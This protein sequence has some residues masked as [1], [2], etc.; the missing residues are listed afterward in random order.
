MKICFN[1]SHPYKHSVTFSSA[2]KSS[3]IEYF[4][5]KLVREI[6]HQLVDGEINY[7]RSKIEHKDK[8]KDSLKVLMNLLK[9][10][11]KVEDEINKTSKI[12]V[13]KWP[14]VPVR[15]QKKFMK[16]RLKKFTTDSRCNML[17][18]FCVTSQIY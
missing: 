4:E 17:F 5:Q 1:L 14:K 15:L 16:Y 12:L 11:G 6:A 18:F 13:T 3:E 2:V 7:K 8:N 10:I 9:N